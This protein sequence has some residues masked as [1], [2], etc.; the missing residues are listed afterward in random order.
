MYESLQANPCH[1]HSYWIV[2]LF[3]EEIVDALEEV[4]NLL[5]ATLRAE[6][7]AFI[8]KYSSVILQLLLKELSPQAV[9]TAL[10]L[11]VGDKPQQGEWGNVVKVFM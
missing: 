5:P 2:S 4:C 9:C 3:Q 11:C 7:N 8:S 10:G 6:C 1:C